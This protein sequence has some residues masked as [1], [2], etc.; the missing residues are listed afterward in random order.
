MLRGF[1]ARAPLDSLRSL[2]TLSTEYKPIIEDYNGATGCIDDEENHASISKRQCIL[3]TPQVSSESI[4]VI[5]IASR[6]NAYQG[7]C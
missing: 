6:S 2:S 1:A 5:S 4:F 3:P 7:D